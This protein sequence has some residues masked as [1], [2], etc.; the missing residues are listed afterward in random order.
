MYNP[1]MMWHYDRVVSA[2]EDGEDIDSNMGAVL[3]QFLQEPETIP[4]ELDSLIM[5]VR[6]HTESYMPDDLSPRVVIVGE[7][8]SSHFLH[9]SPEAVVLLT[10]NNLYPPEELHY[11]RYY[12]LLVLTN[13]SIPE[14]ISFFINISDNYF[15][16]A[17]PDLDMFADAVDVKKYVSD[18]ALLVGEGAIDNYS[19][20]YEMEA[21][22]ADMVKGLL[23]GG[24]IAGDEGHHE[25]WKK[26]VMGVLHNNPLLGAI[27][28][29]YLQEI[30]SKF[31]EP[32]G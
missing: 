11:R 26:E 28:I 23:L 14:A 25:S 22:T 7:F 9:H 3:R 2:L 6:T 17:L 15:E 29:V 5:R 10:G 12:N 31:E 8:L 18:A 16:S 27:A 1:E 4:D 21:T 32:R 13:G 20:L 30:L 24:R 19:F